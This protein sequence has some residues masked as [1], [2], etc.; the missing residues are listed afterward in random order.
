[1]LFSVICTGFTANA[2]SP[3]LKEIILEPTA[4]PKVQFYCTEVTRV[5]AARNS[6]VPGTTI[7][8]ATPS[9][10]PE[11]SGAHASQAYAGET[12]VA[13]TIKFVSPTVGISITGFSCSNETITFSDTKFEAPGTY[14]TYITG[15]SAR[16]GESLVFTIDYAWTDGNM[17]QEK[18]VSYVEGISTGGSFVEHRVTWKPYNGTSSWYRG[19]ASA[20]TRVLGKGVYYENPANMGMT[21]KTGS[22]DVS[23]KSFVEGAGYTYYYEEEREESAGLF[24][25]PRETID[26]TKFVTGT[27]NVH[28]YV[29]SSTALSLADINLRID[30]NVGNEVNDHHV[31]NN[32]SPNVA[33]GETYVFSGAQATAPSSYATDLNA[34]AAIGYYTPARSNY[35]FDSE[36]GAYPTITS[37]AR[38]GGNIITSQLTGA[39]SNIADGSTYT[40][41]NR[42][43]A[44][45]RG[46]YAY[47]TNSPIVPIVMTFHIVDKSAL[48]EAIN[49]VMNT[50]PTDPRVRVQEKGTN[51]QAWYYSSG[52]SD[53]QSAYTSALNVLNN[54]KALQTEINAKVDSLQT[55]YKGLT[56]KGANY[57]KVNELT[58]IADDILNKASCYPES[59]I[60]LINEAKKM[61]VKNYSIL[62]QSSVDLMAYN[63]EFAI[64]RAVPKNADYSTIEA[65]EDEFD[66]ID[67]SDYTPDSVQYVRDL[68]AKVDYTLTALEQSQ[69][70]S[71]AAE[72]RTAID[73]LVSFI[74]L[75]ELNST[76]IS[77]ENTDRNKYCND[78]AMAELDIAIESAVLILDGEKLISNE[79]N[80]LKVNAAIDRINNAVGSLNLH[81]EK[82]VTVENN[83]APTCTEPGSYEG[84]IYCELCDKEL[85]QSLVS[86]DPLGHSPADAVKEK[87]IPATPVKEGSYDSVVYCSECNEELS[88]ENVVI[89]A[90]GHTPAEAVEENRNNATC[91]ENGSYDLVI[92]CTCCEPKVELNRETVEI[93]KIEHTHGEGKSENITEPTCTNPGSYDIVVY[94][95]VCD[96]KISSETIEIPKLGHTEGEWKITAEAGVG[97]AG[98]ETLYCAVCGEAYETR[99][100]PAIT[101]Y[102]KEA[103]KTTT[104]IDKE[105]G[106]IYGLKEGIHDLESFVEYKGGTLQYIK[107]EYGFGTGTIVNF[108]VNGEIYESYTI[109][110]FGDLDGDGVIDTYDATRLAEI[111]NGDI[112]VPEN[113]A[114][115]LAADIENNDK[116]ADTYDLTKLYAAVN[117]DITISQTI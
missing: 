99:E 5:A 67:Y 20:I 25:N 16:V 45:F 6:V 106:F 94:C 73:N 19:Y 101:A 38:N 44:Y 65:L 49:Y 97:V 32:D 113:S 39:V 14:T 93:E 21:Q 82:D 111:V 89:P 57:D 68:F 102:L 66:E 88:R 96:D 11:L 43:Y 13:T 10:I 112:D 60:A 34:Q 12:P 18:C 37:G 104:V 46:S 107:T 105:N 109:V 87:E 26:H 86:V 103:E 62:Y 72:I 50:D 35:G 90:L 7:V 95:T 91:T 69:V 83:V 61:V 17:Y 75:S 41:I 29:D 23:N 58:K 9:G 47:I 84:I 27:P 8:N 115:A 80:T 4:R 52:F 74:D 71:W 117:G 3:G 77:A 59:D 22:Y 30:A 33:L 48:R 114:I 42:Y 51:P 78:E 28:I 36:H 70:D 81:V 56:L 63:L 76:I 24:S 100:I 1:M 110:I 53:F 2:V 98:E 15:G 116:V 54:P 55:A 40:V 64:S 85:S 31:R 108:I 92:Y 79:E